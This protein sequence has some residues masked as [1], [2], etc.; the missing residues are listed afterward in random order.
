MSWELKEVKSYL[1]R[2]YPGAQ[3]H[4]VVFSEAEWGV[5]L[6]DWEGCEDIEGIA[7]DLDFDNQTDVF[8]Y[9]RRAF[10]KMAVTGDNLDQYLHP[11]QSV[12]WPAKETSLCKDAPSF[13]K[14][15]AFP[16][17]GQLLPDTKGKITSIMFV[18][19]KSTEEAIA[20]LLENRTNLQAHVLTLP[21]R[22]LPDQFTREEAF[23][24][25]KHDRFLPAS[26]IPFEGRF[27]YSKALLRHSDWEATHPQIYI[28]DDFHVGINQYGKPFGAAA[29]DE[30]IKTYIAPLL[31]RR[32]DGTYQTDF[33]HRG[34]D[35]LSSAKFLFIPADFR[36]NKD[37]ND[38]QVLASGKE[39]VG[40]DSR[41]IGSAADLDMIFTPTEEVRNGKPVVFLAEE[42]TGF[43]GKIHIDEDNALNKI[44]WEL[45]RRFHVERIPY[46]YTGETE[47]NCFGDCSFIALSYNNVLIER[48]KVNDRLVR[49]VYLPFYK[50]YDGENDKAAQAFR[51]YGY[52]VIP[53]WGLD[54]IAKASGSLRSIVKV[55]SRERLD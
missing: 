1:D 19:A 20:H 37:L 25:S 36:W 29:Y 5:Q 47:R 49:R 34:G 54:E 35:I 7:V 9:E 27:T 39:I 6:N 22:Y 24:F 28:Q 4:E 33:Y 23:Y 8:L 12:D 44:A 3:A 38:V 45:G 17:R 13:F 26:L 42:S 46:I 14:P 48:Y 15:V 43:F 18:A 30:G 55:T 51:Q 41:P 53:I 2:Y 32:F 16:F 40:I 31:G 21:E 10:Q 11:L 50:G 52:E